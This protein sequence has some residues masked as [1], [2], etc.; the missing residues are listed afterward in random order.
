MIKYVSD[1]LSGFEW[2]V[3]G[4]DPKLLFHS[5]THG[6]EFDVVDCVKNSL[7]RY[8]DKLP[9]F[10]F[11]P[12]VSPSAIKNKTRN[13]KNGLDLN[14]SFFRSSDDLEIKENINILEG[15]NFNLFVSFHEDPMSDQYYIYDE[16]GD[17]ELSSKIVKH[18]GFIEQKGISLLNGFDDPD[19]PHLGHKFVEGY[20]KFDHSQNNKA[21]GTVTMWLYSEKRVKSIL[22]P[23]IPG[24]INLGKKAML[25]DSI[26]KNIILN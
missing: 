5:G 7:L 8:I 14:R 18:N 20:A 16:S 11:V 9:S 19:D 12:Y 6:D 17:D 25:V 23:E 1:K 21:D 4:S 26:F 24:K 10:I 13:N 2:Y 22:V 15:C 3:S